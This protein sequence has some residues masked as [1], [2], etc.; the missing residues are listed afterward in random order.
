ML[1]RDLVLSE[2]GAAAARHRAAVFV[3]NGLNARA[4]FA[5]ADRPAN[6]YMMG[7]MGMALSLAVGFSQFTPRPSVVIEG[8][9]NALLG[10]SALPM[11]VRAGAPLVHCV[12]DNGCYESTGAQPS[13]VPDF[14]FSAVARAV[15][16]PVV[17]EATQL[18]SLR[19][20]FDRAVTD[21]TVCFV[22]LRIRPAAPPPPPRIPLHPR[23]I[24]QRFVA[25]E[26]GMPG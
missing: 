26:A 7:S 4:L 14:D 12:L 1:D 23:D 20:A 13:P 15:G 9:G 16:Y 5:L 8:D 17:I 24:T 22:H 10:L 18:G 21:R 6:F 25:A 19:T 3:G 2:I 11:A